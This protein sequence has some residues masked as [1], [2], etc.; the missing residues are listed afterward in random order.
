[1]TEVQKRWVLITGGTGKVGSQLVRALLL[2]GWCVAFTSARAET[3]AKLV[4][5]LTA[6]LPSAVERLV[7]VVSDFSKQTAAVDLIETLREQGIM[8]A[9]LVNNARS[10]ETLRLGPDGRP[11]H[12]Q[13][14]LEF[15]IAVIIAHDLTIGLANEADAQLSVV[16]N[17]S[18][19]YGV[20]AANPNLYAEG[21]L[22]SP[23]HYNVAKAAL[24]HLTKELAVRLRPKVRVN[25][26]SLGGIEGRV[27]TDFKERYAMLCPAGKMLSE[28][29]VIGPIRFLLSQDA[30]SLVGANIPA[31]GGWTIW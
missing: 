19:M 24:I 3:G 13:W 11:T 9:A 25:A 22:S 29:D 31:D 30:A 27:D 28:V 2:D 18:S 23:I 26:L 7:G 10:I 20:V 14:L 8:P 5:S 21:Q 6:E 12:E 4:A 15:Q 17:V 16:V 1:V